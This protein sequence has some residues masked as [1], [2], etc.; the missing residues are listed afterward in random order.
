MKGLVS[1]LQ[2]LSSFTRI[3]DFLFLCSPEFL[4]PA[5]S[6]FGDLSLFTL[7]QLGTQPR[8][9][10]VFLIFGAGLT[11]SFHFG[12]IG[13]K[14]VQSLLVSGL[15]CLYLFLQKPEDR[16]HHDPRSRVG[17]PK[18]LVPWHILDT[19]LETQPW[20]PHL[21]LP[22]WSWVLT[23]GSP[24]QG[25]EDLKPSNSP[26]HNC[27]HLPRQRTDSGTYESSVIKAPD[28]F[29]EPAAGLEFQELGLVVWGW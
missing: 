29:S 20:P 8:S 9:E 24:R 10:G 23:S 5:Q 3:P 22:G 21:I 15:N 19:Y 25:F 12:F 6:L 28:S 14:E 2:S 4:F 11:P 1:K 26:A 18:M 17:L 7:L 16:L 27:Q 13:R